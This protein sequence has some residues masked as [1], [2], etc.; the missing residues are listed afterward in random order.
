ME[1]AEGH[2]FACLRDDHPQCSEVVRLAVL[3]PV[4]L[5]LVAR[6]HQSG[7]RGQGPRTRQSSAGMRSHVRIAVSH[8]HLTSTI[9]AQ[10]GSSESVG[11]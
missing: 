1:E 11:L 9:P 3:K 5:S 6:S 4:K 2:P 8:V 7:S 10:S